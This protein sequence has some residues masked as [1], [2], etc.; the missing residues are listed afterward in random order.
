MK[1]SYSLSNICT[2]ECAIVPDTGTPNIRS[3]SVQA[4][5]AHPPMYAALAPL[6]AASSPWARR[7]P[8][9]EMGL[10]FAARTMRDALV[11]IRDW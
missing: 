7:E 3:E 2:H 8:N 5:D 11:A 10:P 1:A 4:V 9:S 6:T